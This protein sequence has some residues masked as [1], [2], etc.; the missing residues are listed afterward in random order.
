MRVEDLIKI[1]NIKKQINLIVC[2]PGGDYSSLFLE[3]WTEFVGACNKNNI[4][5]KIS[6]AEDAVVYYTR[7]K[8]LC[9]DVLSGKNQKP[10]GGQEN[11][12]YMLWIDSDIVFEFNQFVKLL[13]HNL[14]IVSGI[15]MMKGSEYFATV[16]DW[17]IE[18]FRKN[19]YF[20]FL[21]ENDIKNISSLIE[22]AYT[23]FGFML[24]K[25]GVFEALEYPWFRPLW[26]KISENVED[27]SSEDVSFCRSII[28]K[29]YKIYIDP[30]VR[31]GHEKRVVL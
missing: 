18:H 11:Y 17:D 7:N 25:H 14:D 6:S 23:G 13:N 10:F 15:Y 30:T 16:K 28:E 29:G 5:L 21:T 31:V 8:C 26:Q 3:C 12:D 20:N 4:N 19:G 2:L 27:F 24:V 9:G 22:V 1:D